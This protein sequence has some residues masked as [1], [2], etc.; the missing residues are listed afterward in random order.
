MVSI[1]TPNGMSS[2]LITVECA[3]ADYFFRSY[4][5]IDLSIRPCVLADGAGLGSPKSHEQYV[6]SPMY[7]TATDT[8]ATNA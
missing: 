2:T 4:I 6:S 8:T 3:K 5:G 7:S 1:S